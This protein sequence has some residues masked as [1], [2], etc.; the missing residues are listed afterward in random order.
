M[1]RN[2]SNLR[3]RTA[4]RALGVVTA[5]T[6]SAPALAHPHAWI[7]VRSTLILDE[8]GRV[9]AIEEQWLFDEFYTSVALEG[10]ELPQS[11][12][13]PLLTEL[14]K[15]NLESLRAYDY[16]TEVR[17]GD[18]R[19]NVATVTEYKTAMRDGRLWMEFV[20]PLQEPIDPKQAQL[21]YSIYDPTYY[22]EMLHL[23]GDV[24]AFRGGGANSC[25][26]QIIP[27]NPTTETVMLAGAMDRNA[28]PNDGLGALFAEWVEITCR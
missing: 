20:L 4:L 16:F 1:R 28:A 9:V 7:D 11:G 12:E 27:P 6:A 14:A 3:L 23:E 8:A 18:T 5:V 15:S 17:S 25:S 2:G 19:L 22:I 24:V 10:A 13:H 26:A 21:S